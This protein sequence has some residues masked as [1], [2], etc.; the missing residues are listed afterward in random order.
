MYD[1]VLLR[2]GRRDGRV[3]AGRASAVAPPTNMLNTKTMYVCI[4]IYTYIY[5]H[6][7]MYIYIYIYIYNYIYIIVTNS[8]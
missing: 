5:I 4:Y 2:P 6:T 1:L 3:A 8:S 7:N